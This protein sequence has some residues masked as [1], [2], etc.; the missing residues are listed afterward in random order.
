MV[1]IEALLDRLRPLGATFA[2]QE[3]RA[4]GL[5][6]RDLYA[7]R[8]Q[9]L[10]IALSRGLYQLGEAAGDIEDEDFVVVCARAPRAMI[11]LNSALAYWDLSD[12]IPPAV[13]LAI[14]Q[15]TSRPAL[16]YPPTVVHVFA[17]P[18]FELGMQVVAH[19]A[20]TKFRITDRERTVVDA[21]RLRHRL[22]EDIAHAALRRYLRARPKPA[23]VAD[24]A[25]ALRVW[26]PVT[27]AIRL[28]SA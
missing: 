22:G 8:E 26:H 25:R 23:V 21:F 13:H 28:L 16:D 2:A 9:G 11:C 27:D 20:G 12:E 6:W 18:S 19:E 15:G 24:M 10:I 17:A 5:A 7:L 4:A 1:A 3:A 14:P